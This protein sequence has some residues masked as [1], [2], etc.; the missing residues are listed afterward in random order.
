MNIK[1][2]K[3]SNLFKI[4]AEFTA[5]QLIALHNALVKHDSPVGKDNLNEFNAAV[6]KSQI[7]V[8][9]NS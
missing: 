1:Q 2:I 7:K 4:E 9:F 8:K 5:G 3:N 6:K